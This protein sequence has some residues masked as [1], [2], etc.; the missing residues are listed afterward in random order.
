MAS[1]QLSVNG[2]DIADVWS[3]LKDKDASGWGINRTTRGGQWEVIVPEDL[4]DTRYTVYFQMGELNNAHLRVEVL[5]AE[6]KTVMAKDKPAWSG[7]VPNFAV[8]F[9]KPGQY[10][11]RI[12]HAGKDNGAILELA[13]TIFVVPE[14][15]DTLPPPAW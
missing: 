5:D 14:T 10:S 6:G 4:A 3:P 13:N 9:P 1:K 12:L 2:R 15:A 7:P 11:I 8:R